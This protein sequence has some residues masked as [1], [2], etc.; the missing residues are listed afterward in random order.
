MEEASY[1]LYKRSP[2]AI[3]T[4]SIIFFRFFPNQQPVWTRHE[5]CLVSF[6]SQHHCY[7]RSNNIRLNRNLDI[8]EFSNPTDIDRVP[9]S[10][11]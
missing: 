4:D 1:V 9:V 10:S 2:A 11:G 3:V 7:C 8:H 5:G 6:G